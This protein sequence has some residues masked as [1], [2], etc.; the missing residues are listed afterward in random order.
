MNAGHS[1]HATLALYHIGVGYDITL[2]ALLM[3]ATATY[4]IIVY[5]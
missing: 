2:M 5:V 1:Q 3:L 4:A